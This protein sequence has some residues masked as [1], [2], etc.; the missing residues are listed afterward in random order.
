MKK[1]G[2]GPRKK[3]DVDTCVMCGRIVPEG[4]QVCRMCRLKV[5]NAN[6]IVRGISKSKGWIRRWKG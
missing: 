6:Q 4:T 1:W 5:S 3:Q 2:N